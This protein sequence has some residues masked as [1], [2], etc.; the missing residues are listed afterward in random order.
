MKLAGVRTPEACAMRPRGLHENVPN[1]QVASSNAPQSFHNQKL[2]AGCPTGAG[3]A[4][5]TVPPQTAD[6]SEYMARASEGWRGVMECVKH[7]LRP[8]TLKPGTCMPELVRR[9]T[10]DP[11]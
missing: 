9:G 10:A 1:G 3:C 8:L 4:C 7:Q 5:C 11:S 6:V 2:L